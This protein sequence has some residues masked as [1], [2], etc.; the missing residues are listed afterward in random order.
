VTLKYLWFY[1]GDEELNAYRYNEEK[2]LS[3]LQRRAER[4]AETLKQRGV[5]V[6][7]GSISANFVRSA[8]EN[9]ADNGK[10]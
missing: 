10:R 2:T 7:G 1:P 9:T 3:W 8:A 6:S 4:V 5:H